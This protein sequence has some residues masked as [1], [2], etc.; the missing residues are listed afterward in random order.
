MSAGAAAA[1]PFSAAAE[2]NSGPWLALLRMLLP[3]QARVLEV[4]SGTGQHA[5]CCAAAQRGWHWQPSERDA[6]ALP[7]IARRCAGL[8]NVA[9]PLQIDLLGAGALG[10]LPPASFDAVVA[11]NLLHIAP[12]PVCAALMQAAARLL[13]PQACLVVYGPF[14]VEGQPTAPSNLAFDADLQSRNPAWG[15]RRLEDVA[16]QAGR[17]G[18]VL[19]DTVQMPANNLSLVLRHSG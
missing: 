8:P 16:D 6:D 2:R 1:L 4:A 18:L 3:P 9:A 13:A 11:M 19:H 10:T 17:A 14:V 7:W 15:L 12:W 5:V